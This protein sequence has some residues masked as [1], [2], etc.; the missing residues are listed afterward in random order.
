MSFLFL[1]I[2]FDENLPL[3][4]EII[5]WKLFVPFFLLFVGA[6]CHN[7]LISFDGWIGNVNGKN[8]EI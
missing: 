6:F 3:K 8:T 1:G 4:I 2:Y 5:L 7:K